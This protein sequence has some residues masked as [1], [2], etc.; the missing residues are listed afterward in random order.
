MRTCKIWIRG[1]RVALQLCKLN[2]LTRSQSQH[3]ISDC[4]YFLT[5]HNL[6]STFQSSWLQ[7]SRMLEI[8][9]YVN[10][11]VHSKRNIK[12]LL[13]TFETNNMDVTAVD[14]NE[15]RFIFHSGLV[16]LYEL[17]K[18][19]L[20]Y[21]VSHVHGRLPVYL[22][23]HYLVNLLIDRS[24]GQLHMWWTCLLTGILVSYISHSVI[25]AF[26]S[27]A[28]ITIAVGQIKV[29][30][31]HLSYIA[32]TVLGGFILGTSSLKYRSKKQVQF[33]VSYCTT[34]Y[35]VSLHETA[36]GEVVCILYYW[37]ALLVCYFTGLAC[38]TCVKYLHSYGVLKMAF[39]TFKKCVICYSHKSELW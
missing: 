8:Q 13:P 14:N 22:K 1:S 28:A 26:T 20:A 23:L 16:F 34:Q 2:T 17:W 37:P 31:P 25:N 6:F 24:N 18:Y 29:S 36:L 11:N 32:Y 30:G 12:N 38:G 3:L 39:Q 10:P 4:V 33:V 21:D 27:A 19:W 7:A 15:L 5:E 9:I 35:A